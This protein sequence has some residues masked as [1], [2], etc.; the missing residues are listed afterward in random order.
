[1]MKYK[2]IF[3]EKNITGFNETS[4][5]W[6]GEGGSI[7]LGFESD[8]FEELTLD[9]LEKAVSETLYANVEKE[10]IYFIN[11]RLGVLTVLENGAGDFDLEGKFMCD[12]WFHVVEVKEPIN[13]EI[14]F[15]D[16]QK[17][18]A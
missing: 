15:H 5:D 16:Q 17:Q 18:S 13:L 1:M 6:S 11:G 4:Q 2:V 8:V 7:N 14:Y 3:L 10:S 9:N 12:Y